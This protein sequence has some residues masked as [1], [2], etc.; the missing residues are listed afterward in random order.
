ME[1]HFGPRV[2]IP[3]VD[4]GHAEGERDLEP[5]AIPRR[6]HDGL[7]LG[8]C[9]NEV[10]CPRRDT[11]WI[12][13]AK[14]RPGSGFQWVRWVSS[15]HPRA[16]ARRCACPSYGVLISGYRNP[17]HPPNPLPAYPFT[18]LRQWVSSGSRGLFER[19][20]EVGQGRARPPTPLRTPPHEGLEGQGDTAAVDRACPRTQ[21]ACH[22]Q[23]AKL[24]SQVCLWR[25]P[26]RTTVMGEDIHVE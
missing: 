9:R 25:G 16:R 10:K 6:Q 4:K 17:P 14:G 26:N 15:I 12:S 8:G 7:R 23:L 18:L 2:S 1:P 3:R 22:I 24:R 19:V 13:K 11:L 5:G 21:N 20:P